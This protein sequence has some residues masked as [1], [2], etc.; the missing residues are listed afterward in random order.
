MKY[1]ML[2][3]WDAEHMNTQAEPEQPEEG[4]ESFRGST[5]CRRVGSG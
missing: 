4:K 5:T 2:V 3:C 1:M